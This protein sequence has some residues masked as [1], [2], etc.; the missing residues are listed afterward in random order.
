MRSI[1]KLLPILTCLWSIIPVSGQNLALRYDQP[2][3]HGMTEGIPIGNGRFGAMIYGDPVH[4]I[5]QFNDKSFWTGSPTQ[6]G[7]Y[8]SFGRIELN[9]DHIGTVDNYNRSL[10]LEK[11]IAYV[12]YTIHDVQYTHEYLAS[13][14]D[15]VI[16]IRLSANK[17]GKLN[18]AIRLKGDHNEVVAV[19]DQQMTL[20]G[21]LTILD[22]TALLTVVPEGGSIRK[23]IDKIQVSNA[24]QVTIYLAANTSYDPIT[25]TYTTANDWASALT[26]TIQKAQKQGYQQIKKR[27]IADHGKLF[28][29]VHFNLGD[30]KNTQTTDR[31]MDSYRKGQYDPWV[32]ILLFQYGRYLSIASSRPNLDQPSNLQGIWNDSNTPPWESDIHSNINVQMNYWPV[33]V[34]NLSEC[35]LPFINYIYNEAQ[36]QPSWRKMANENQARGWTMKTQN[37]IFGYSDW[38]WNRPA[39]AWY[40]LHTWDHYA[41]SPNRDYLQQKAYPVLKAACEFW[42]DRLITGS[43]GQLLAPNE[44]SPEHGPWEDGIAYVQ[45]LINELFQNTLYAGKVLQLNDDFQ[46]QLQAAYTKLDKGMAVGSWGQLREWRIQNDDP[47]DQHR[48]VSHLIALYPGTAISS[49][50]TP[51]Y[52]QAARKSLEARGD[53]G[54]GW[55]LAWK[56]AFWARLQDG[57]KAHALFKRAIK[58]I[59]L[60]D[61]HTEKG[62]LYKNL[63]NGPPFQIEANFGLT[64]GLSEML[65]QSQMDEIHLL[66]ALPKEWQ[67]GSISGLKSRGGYTVDMNWNKRQLT[68]ATITASVDGI[69]TIRTNVP[70]K[71]KQRNAVSKLDEFGY[72]ITSWPVKAHKTYHL[73]T[74]K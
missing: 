44:W 47:K 51:V 41:F 56:T 27:H 52:A 40:A 68:N 57:D 5:I 55:G 70:L 28:N 26:N 63:F 48:H 2:A 33:E 11:A 13:Y 8:Q 62:G 50:K 60:A 37:N 4:E 25:P 71:I 69:C 31:L 10:D 34:T 30:T 42:L 39:N 12:N 49:F 54:P 36:I 64:A 65:I 73:I 74:K 22:Y 15:D 21:K 23:D 14:P 6:R 61:T 32:D 72:Y 43:D 16:A 35:H 3:Q 18:F 29:R 38:N 24:D 46:Q 53:D 7:A 67:K 17:K 45:Q 66:P 9:F 20:S 59:S 19:G 1:L 58:S